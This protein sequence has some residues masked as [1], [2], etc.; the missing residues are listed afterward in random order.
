MSDRTLAAQAVLVAAQRKQSPLG[1]WIAYATI[2]VVWGTTFLAVRVA[3]ETVPT[4]L[5]TAVR[6]LGT[7]ARVGAPRG[8]HDD[9]VTRR[10]IERLSASR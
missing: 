1:A 9:H 7:A 8:T 6:F 2:C 4:L 10:A 3:I 5:V